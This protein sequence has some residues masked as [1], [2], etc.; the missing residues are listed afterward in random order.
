VERRVSRFEPN[1]SWRLTVQA[2]REFALIPIAVVAV[3]M[4]LA[5]ASILADQTTLPVLSA[6]GKAF[7]TVIGKDASTNALQSIATGMLTVTSITFSVLLLAVQQTA[8][9]LSPVVFDQFI[10][11]RI[12]Q[13]LLGFF[14][15]LSLYSYVVMAAVKGNKPPLAGAGVATVLTVV[16][17]LLLLVLVY[18]TI[19]QMRPTNVL[20]QIHDRALAARDRQSDLRAQTMRHEESGRPVTATYHSDA[21]GYVTG[22]DLEALAAALQRVP[23][24]EIRLQV[25]LGQAVSF[26]DVIATV[27]DDEQE[28]ANS[29][30]RE[31]RKAIRLE[32]RRNIDW[33]ATTGIAEITNIGWTSGSTAKQSPHVAR[34]ALDA[35][36]DLAARWIEDEHQREKA[37]DANRPAPLRVVYRDDD[38]DAVL[39]SMYSLMVSAHESHQHLTAV[40]VLRAYGQLIPRVGE[41]RAGEQIRGRILRDLDAMEPLLDALPP[42]PMLEDARAD[43]RARVSGLCADGHAETEVSR[44]HDAARAVSSP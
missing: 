22:I 6:I 42:S 34:Q 24:A 35:L 29:L 39:D 12:N 44:A 5:A 20:R 17:M 32:S 37:T 19:D 33:D 1:Q 26:G 36:K 14:V 41:L 3:F 31:V 30:M 11:R 40:H 2:V 10:R 16:A 13:T 21:M 4:V 9:N 43:L 25:T 28:E 7:G 8:S 27:R 23:R 15:G 18:T 38:L